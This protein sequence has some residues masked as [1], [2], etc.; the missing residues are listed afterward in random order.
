MIKHLTLAATAA[1]ALFTTAPAQAGDGDFIGEILMFGG[2]FCPRG[3][4]K[5]DGQILP[6]ATNQALFSLYGTNYGGDGRTTFG[7]PDLTRFAPD[8]ILYCVAD[9]GIYPSRS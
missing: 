8:G 5:A 2:T 9:Q 6:I 1:A 7:V 4:I 3:Y